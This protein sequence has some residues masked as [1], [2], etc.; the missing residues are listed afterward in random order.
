MPMKKFS[1][2]MTKRSVQKTAL[3]AC[4]DC[5][6]LCCHDLSVTILKPSTGKEIDD[7]MW[8]LNYD[9]V[10]VY[11]QSRRWHL[12]VKGRCQYLD[13]RNMCTIYDKRFSTCRNHKPPYCEKFDD[14]Y[15]VMFET[16]FELQ[17][18][19]EKEKARWKKNA[20]KRKAKRGTIK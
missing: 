16:P 20:K 19:L 17:E 7:L 4:S 12:H 2:P 15:D 6:A 18:Y 1:T 11:I 10:R 3:D 13:D 8:H 5:P 14:W 9:T